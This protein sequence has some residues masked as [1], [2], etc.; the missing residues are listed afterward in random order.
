MP[1]RTEIKEIEEIRDPYP[2][3]FAGRLRAFRKK[4]KIKQ[5][6]FAEMLHIDIQKCRR[7][8][9]IGTEPDVETL[10]KMASI[11]KI[12]VDELVGYKPAAINI[13]TDIL[14]KSGIVFKKVEDED[15]Y[16]L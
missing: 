10:K 1:T 2:K 9:S 13:A 11:L 6:E 15:A 8:E 3:D 14:D 16:I 12:T 7:Y 5:T 4:L